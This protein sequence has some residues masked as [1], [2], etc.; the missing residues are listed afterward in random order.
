MLGLFDRVENPGVE[1][2]PLPGLQGQAGLVHIHL[3]RPPH[4]EEILKL[5]VPVPRHRI[6]GQ[7]LG[8]AGD[9]KQRA[10]VLHKFPALFAGD[11]VGA[12]I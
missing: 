4:R 6:A 8:I 1:E 5:L 10:T 12:D 11:D 7:I 3:Q 9:G 2:H